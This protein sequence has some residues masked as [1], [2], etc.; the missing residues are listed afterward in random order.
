MLLF[1]GVTTGRRRSDSHSHLGIPTARGSAV[2]KA[3]WG[4]NMQLEKGD[5]GEGSHQPR[6]TYVCISPHIPLA[7]ASHMVPP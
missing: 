3:T 7:R 4:I 6:V 5:G 2:F 1:I